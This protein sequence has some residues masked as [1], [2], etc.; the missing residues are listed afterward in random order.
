MLVGRSRCAMRMRARRTRHHLGLWLLIS[1]LRLYHLV[2][3]CTYII[4]AVDHTSRLNR[5]SKKGENKHRQSRDRQL[6]KMVDAQS[7]P[8]ILEHLTK[9][10]T[11][12]I[13][14]TRCVSSGQGE[15]RVQQCHAPQSRSCRCAPTRAAAY[16]SVAACRR[17]WCTTPTHPPHRLSIPTQVDPRH[18]TL[19]GGRHPPAQHRLHPGVRG[20]APEASGGACCG[21]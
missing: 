15:H 21:Q 8:Q 17:C 5:D 16:S 2:Y 14:S 13:H 11:A 7:K 4:L 9:S 1:R 20:C 6:H 3:T 10:V 19:P 12:T 18:R